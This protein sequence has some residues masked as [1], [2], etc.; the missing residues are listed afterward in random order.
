MAETV[1][2]NDQPVENMTLM[3]QDVASGVYLG[4]E[5]IKPGSVIARYQVVISHMGFKVAK[6]MAEK[7][8]V[9]FIIAFDL[10]SA[11]WV[12][13]W[14][15]S[16][17]TS[18]LN[19]IDLMAN[20][21]L[22]CY[23]TCPERFRDLVMDD[24]EF[25]ARF[26][27]FG[28]LILRPIYCQDQCGEIR[29]YP[30]AMWELLHDDVAPNSAFPSTMQMP[31]S[32][33]HEGQCFAHQQTMTLICQRPIKPGDFVSVVSR[34]PFS[35]STSI[36][37][38]GG[39]RHPS[40]L[41]PLKKG[42][43]DMTFTANDQVALMITGKMPEK[44]KQEYERGFQLARQLML[45]SNVGTDPDDVEYAIQMLE[46]M[47]RE[48]NKFDGGPYH[49]ECWPMVLPK[50]AVVVLFALSEQ[51][52]TKCKATRSRV[53]KVME[54]HELVRCMDSMGWP[55]VMF[56]LWLHTMGH[57]HYF[58]EKVFAKMNS[59]AKQLCQERMGCDPESIVR[60]HNCVL[61]PSMHIGVPPAKSCIRHVAM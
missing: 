56:D 28:A 50:A 32:G 7:A 22:R 59:E 31:F 18:S 52:R 14:R 8:L 17:R 55:I 1:V 16:V 57:D 5:D 35:T 30:E 4:E 3:Q 19:G 23:M 9:P 29:L 41:W 58:E 34:N 53:A 15:T 54:K 61:P 12:T 49:N 11:K 2:F 33:S 38:D 27:L 51:A 21:A 37:S 10:A 24:A 20:D 43:N 39:E 60:M 45:S 48:N 13:R 6:T 47:S 44:K 46:Q 25:E 26:A 40:N 36:V 42:G